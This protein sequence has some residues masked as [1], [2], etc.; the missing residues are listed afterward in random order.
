MCLKPAALR[1]S[2]AV[3]Q[4]RADA[5]GI[6]LRNSGAHIACICSSDAL[7]GEGATH[8]ARELKAAGA[9]LIMLAG[10]PPRDEAAAWNETILRTAG[11]GGFL[12]AGGDILAALD[13]AWS[14]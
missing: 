12:H 9:K 14:A 2:A 3:N 1:L 7:Y 6:A 8:V 13:Q 11:I 4:Q 10:R 5:I